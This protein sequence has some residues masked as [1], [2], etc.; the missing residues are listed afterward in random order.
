MTI[1]QLCVAI[2]AALSSG[3]AIAHGQQRTL[4]FHQR[5]VQLASRP[6]LTDSARLAALFD[7]DWEYTNVESPETA[8]YVGYPGQDERWSDN[9]PAAI[10][11]RRR[12]LADRLLVLAA[13]DRRR[14]GPS[15]RLSFD[16]FKRS[17]DESIEGARF[18]RELLAVTQREGPQYVPRVLGKMPT[19]SVAEYERIITR[20]AALP[21]VL[22][23]TRALLDSGLV[24]GVT[25]PSVT[26]RDVPAQF[27]QLV[28]EAPMQSALLEPFTRFPPAIAPADRQRL[29]AEATR[30]YVERVRP[31]YRALASYLRST[32][33]PRARTSIAWSSLPD[34]RAWY[35][36]NVKLETT[37]SRTPAEIHAL[38]LAEVKRIRAEMDTAIRASGY[39]GD[40]ASFVAM[41]RTDTRFFMKDSASL[42]R[43]YRDIAKRIDPELSRLFGR[44]PR[45]TYGVG[46]I[47]SYAAPSQTTAYYMSGSPD[48][49]LPGM[50]VVNTYKLDS[51]P[52]WEMEALTAH[53]AVPGHHLQIALSQEM[54][55]LPPFRRYSG[56]TAFTEGWGL[57]AESLG[58]ELGLYRDPYSKF[59]QLTYEMWRAIRLVLDTGIHEF[60]WTR[61]QAIA[62]FEANSAKTKQDIT[63]EVDRYIVM[64]AQAL[65]YKSGELAMRAMR[66]RAE[67]QQGARF[68]IR[69]FHDELL[70]QCALP[71]D[72]LERR[73]EEWTTRTVAP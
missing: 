63:S 26:L 45:L 30:V 29:T 20:L 5:F 22:A 50:Y 19:S 31:A 40:F 36:Y 62:Y 49:H 70:S 23:Q 65:A 61:E 60:G 44:L 72:I 10:A 35:A 27:E 2:A 16:I 39:T 3:S 14:L 57:Y 47:P 34:G 58:S 56:Y 69:A 13:I 24:I 28:P 15:D 17:I 71:L 52:I 37:T 18:P 38:G 55:D 4:D 68:D 59:G 12:E 66:A 46:T 43:A 9:S 6:S 73:M 11:R 1:R 7:L 33:V 53:E 64:P 32:Y 48:A 8:T 51:R 54:N 25:P 21:T 42:V 67:R 41:L